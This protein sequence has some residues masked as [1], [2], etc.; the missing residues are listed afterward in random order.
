MIIRDCLPSRLSCEIEGIKHSYF[1]KG[2]RSQVLT[3]Q[4]SSISEKSK[5]SILVNE[6][7]GRFEVMSYELGESE[8]IGFIDHFTRQ[9]RNS[10][11]NHTQA[12]E[13]VISAIRGVIKKR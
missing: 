13:A 11:Y 8:Q 6:I 7:V 3:I 12:R 5:F 1:E 10:G 9:I 2:M 4:M